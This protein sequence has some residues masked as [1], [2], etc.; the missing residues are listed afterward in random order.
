MNRRIARRR[1]LSV[2]G[3]GGLF[4]ACGESGST[5]SVGTACVSSGDGPG[6]SYCLVGTARILV[7]GATKLAVG[8]VVLVTVDDNSA[9]IVARDANGL[10]GLSAICTHACCVVNVCGGQGCS[11]PALTPR[12]CDPPAF[13]A[14]PSSGAAFLCPC[15]GSQFA[16]SGAVISGPATKALPS[17]RVEVIGSD[18]VVDLGHGVQ[19]GARVSVS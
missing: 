13:L 8:Q 14:L 6:L 17:L 7:A 9:A 18:V 2:L 5:S 3:A 16:A 4:A 12:A 19:P 15:H 10:Y 1:F 11:A